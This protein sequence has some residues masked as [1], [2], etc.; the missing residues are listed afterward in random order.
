MSSYTAYINRKPIELGLAIQCDALR[1]VLV[2]SQDVLEERTWDVA[3][4]SNNA[5]P[6]LMPCIL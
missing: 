5:F 4:L 6:G 2:Y 3:S 1:Y